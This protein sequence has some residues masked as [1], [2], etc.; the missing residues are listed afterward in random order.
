MSTSP[1]NDISDNDNPN[2]DDEDDDDDDPFS[3][4]FKELSE[5]NRLADEIARVRSSVSLSL[6]I[7]NRFSATY[8]SISTRSS[9][10]SCNP[11]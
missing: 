1:T 5:T 9:S 8:N 10:S 7:A 3:M 6:L 2:E 4:A 11:S